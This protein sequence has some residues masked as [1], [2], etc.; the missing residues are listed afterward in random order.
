MNSR[1][2]VAAILAIV[3]CAGPALLMAQQPLEWSDIQPDSG[4]WSR[5]YFDYQ[6]T[7]P[8]SP[9]TFYCINDW[10]VNQKD[11]CIHGGLVCDSMF[12]D[13]T[14]EAN[15]FQFR[16]GMTEYTIKIY[17]N[18]KATITPD[19][20]PNF[21]GKF[22]WN[23]SVNAPNI[24]HTI[25]EFSFDIKDT[26]LVNFTG[27][28]PAVLTDTVWN[29]GPPSIIHN[30]PSKYPHEVDGLFAN[31]GVIGSVGCS[32]L[33]RSF[34]PDSSLPKDPRIPPLT[35]ILHKGGGVTVIPEGQQPIPSLT[36]WGLIS[37][38]LVLLALATLVF[39]WRRKVVGV[40][41]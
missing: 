11:D 20:L 1:A 28:D 17:K 24:N 5:I 21:K 32:P 2:I 18:K 41:S 22:S 23:T 19:S 27:H 3:F 34:I 33:G 13:T 4:R 40:R 8:N 7:N 9:G 15:L 10:V 12:P 16:M 29:P 39:F 36:E 35:I 6:Q 14:C 25:W 31:Y 38:L 26:F 37:L 30:D